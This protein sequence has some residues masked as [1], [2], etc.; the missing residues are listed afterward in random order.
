MRIT[1]YY[2]PDEAQPYNKERRTRFPVAQMLKRLAPKLRG[3][4]DDFTLE[5]AD[6]TV[7][8]GDDAVAYVRRYA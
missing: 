5:L 1:L 8:Q 3:I 6:G 7:L 2:D 4:G